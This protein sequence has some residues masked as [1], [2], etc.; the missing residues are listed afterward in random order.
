LFHQVTGFFFLVFGLIVGFAAYREYLAY[1]AAKIG[2]ARAIL[3][4]VLALL[5][6]YFALSAFVNAGRKKK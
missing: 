6:I 5:F 2:P 4:G 3:A 1:A